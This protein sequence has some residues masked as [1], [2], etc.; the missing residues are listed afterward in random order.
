MKDDNR[1]THYGTIEFSPPESLKTDRY[2]NDKSDN[3]AVGYDSISFLVF[4]D[5]C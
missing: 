2:V 4:Q 3:F 5:L 1:R